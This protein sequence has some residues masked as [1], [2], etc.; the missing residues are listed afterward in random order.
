MYMYAARLA[1]HL[2]LA[3][4]YSTVLPLGGSTFCHAILEGEM[5]I[6]NRLAKTILVVAA[7]PLLTALGPE[8]SIDR[9]EVF[10]DAHFER[11]FGFMMPAIYAM[12]ARR[13]MHLYGTTREQLAQV[14]V[15]ARR[16][17]QLNPWPNT[18]APFPS[19]ECGERTRGGDPSG[20]LRLL[21]HL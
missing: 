19:Q 16:H 17:A 3:P 7:D 11:P 8:G 14:A 12:A 10:Q 21:S 20:R 5:V 9:F 18:A 2:R 1:A 15:S 4:S 13:H 6:R